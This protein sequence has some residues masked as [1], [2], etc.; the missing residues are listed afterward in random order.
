MR[1]V[2]SHNI[3]FEITADNFYHDVD[4]Q[5][6]LDRLEND[7]L[8]IMPETLEDAQALADSVLTQCLSTYMDQPTC[9][10]SLAVFI[11]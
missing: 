5:W 7:I 8:T 9:G 1:I 11:A 6:C 4:A 2:K 10:Y 3:T